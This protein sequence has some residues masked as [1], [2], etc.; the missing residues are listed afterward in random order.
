MDRLWESLPSGRLGCGLVSLF[1][2]VAC[3]VALRCGMQAKNRYLRRF[4]SDCGGAWV[5]RPGID[6]YWGPVLLSCMPGLVPCAFILDSLWSMNGVSQLEWMCHQVVALQLGFLAWLTVGMV[7]MMLRASACP[8]F[9]IGRCILRLCPLTTGSSTLCFNAL[10]AQSRIFAL[11]LRHRRKR[12]SQRRCRPFSRRCTPFLGGL[13]QLLLWSFSADSSF[14]CGAT[15]WSMPFG[16]YLWGLGDLPLHAHAM[17]RPEPPEE[18]PVAA[19]VRPHDLPA[20]GLATFV[21]SNAVA[22][23]WAA[24]PTDERPAWLCHLPLENDADER[25]QDPLWLGVQVFTPNF[26]PQYLGLRVAKEAGLHA[27][28]DA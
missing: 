7:G 21:G 28:L 10:R 4:F 5:T 16:C 13:W 18:L 20:D 8:R 24:A 17:A 11:A 2:G 19:P 14:A 26:R 1:W 27:A 15:P 25:G 22:V 9:W 3:L 6:L 12:N 23:P